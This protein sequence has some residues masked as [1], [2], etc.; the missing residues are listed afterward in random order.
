MD[1]LKDFKYKLIKNFFSPKEIKLLKQYCLLRLDGPWTSDPQC[2]Y[3]APSFFDD[4]LMRYYHQ[5][6]L[7][8]VEKHSK[9][10]LFKSY[11][12]WRYYV[13]GSI[14]KT[15]IDRPSCEVS[16]TACISQTEQWPIHINNKWYKLNEGDAILYAGHEVPHGRKPF[17]GDSNAQ[18]FFHYVDQHGPFTHHKDDQF[19]KEN[20]R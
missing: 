2:G 10:K 14:L 13:Y 19:R 16:V 7:K 20:N 9:L 4:A 8:L 15:H 3:I 11:T 6:K 12:Y 17:T 18:V 5:E 1:T